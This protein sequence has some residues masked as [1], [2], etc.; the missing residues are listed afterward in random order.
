ML[1]HQFNAIKYSKKLKGAGME[2]KLADLHA[3]ELQEVINNDLVT[4]SDLN[5]LEKS[6]RN[7]MLNL[8]QRM[9][10]KLGSLMVIGIGVIGFLIKMG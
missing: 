1:N 8:E 4:K 2:A 6:L 7:D 3:E 9:T 5:T 10:V